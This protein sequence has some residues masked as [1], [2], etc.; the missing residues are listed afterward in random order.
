MIRI[1]FNLM[2]ID[3]TVDYRLVNDSGIIV[4]F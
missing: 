4:T 1:N 3:V 2:I